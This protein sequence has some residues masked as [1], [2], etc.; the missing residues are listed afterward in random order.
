MTQTRTPC[1]FV[2]ALAAILSVVR[3]DALLA[4][5]N[6]KSAPKRIPWTTSRVQGTPEPPPPFR[7][8]RVF[9]K[10]NFRRP[11]VITSAPGTDRFFVAQNYDK[12]FSIANDPDV[13]KSDLFLDTKDLIEQLNDG[14][15]EE[16][17]MGSIYGLTFHPDFETNRFCYLC[18]VVSYKAGGKGQHPNGTRVV[19]LTVSRTDP[20]VADP[21]SEVL[22]IDWLQG[23]H[24][25]G[26]IK[27]GLDGSLFVSTGD[28]GFAFPP[29][30][31]NSGQDV[32]NLLSA[33]LRIDVD[34]P[35]NGMNYSIPS[36]NP[37]VNLD[38][39]RG[40]IWAYGMRN[41]WKISVDRESGDLW[42]GDVGWESWELVYR[43]Q[44]G[45]NYGW[46]LVEGP[47]P[48]HTERKRGPT[49]IVPPAVA[50]PHTDGAS[51]TG[52]FVYRGKKFPELVG[53]YIFG[54][55]ETRRIW[56]VT[57]DGDKISPMKELVEPTVRIV[58]F[59]ED[60]DGELYLLDYDDG[61]IHTLIRN[62]TEKPKYPFPTKLSESGLFASVADHELADG[63][64][65]YAINA[66]LWADFAT[67]ER[68][69][70]IPGDASVGFHS[71]AVRV[72]GSMFERQTDYPTGTVLG[73]TLS[74][75][76]VKSGDQSQTRRVET[77][78]LHFDGQFWRGYSYEWN[79]E[80]TDAVLLEASGK[81][82]SIPVTKGALGGERNH[83]WKFHS[84]YECLRC[85]NPWSEYTLAFN[86]SQLN[87]VPGPET[88]SSLK[89]NQVDHFRSIGVIRD[90]LREPDPENPFDKG[91]Q[92]KSV[93]ELPRLASPFY[94]DDSLDA[95][96]RAYLHVNCAHCH[97]NGGGGSAYLHLN[98]DLKL[99]ET[100]ALAKRPTQGTFA[101]HDAEIL[102]P[103]DPYRSVLY[104]RLAKLGSGRMPHIGSKL[105]DTEGLDL[106]HDWIR[107]LPVRSEDSGIVDK[108][109]A[110]DE[111]AI[112]KR[113]E[114]DRDRS[115]FN[116]AR[117]VAKE[118]ERE[119]E[120]PTDAD[121][122]EAV[123]RYEGAAAARV[124]KRA[125]DRAS[126]IEELL[127]DPSR[128]ILL[129][130]EH[131][132]NRIPESMVDQVLMTAAK[133]PQP[134]IRD[135]FEIFLP[136]DQRSKRL[137][138]VINPRELLALDGNADRGRKLF[139]ET[140]GIQC[141]NCHR[142]AGKGKSLGPDLD[143][144]AK[145]NSKAKLLDSILD[146]SRNIDPKFAAWLVETTAGRVHVGLLAKKTDEEVV[147]R[148]TEGKE[149]RIAA[150][151]VEEMFPQRKS[152]MPDLQLRDM[153][154]EQVA[155]LLAFLASLK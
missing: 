139:V 112:V 78:L 45:D 54:D 129:L 90:I 9:P 32:S 40:E 21:K 117:A 2:C 22:I 38:D 53:T 118:N 55:W 99:T 128:A 39:A 33:V 135:L 26:C 75:G 96:A 95:R 83:E 134:Q 124:T 23:G 69:I 137:G 142:V 146:P 35:S 125:A 147:L 94:G 64:A 111:P 119:E 140:Q 87:H 141:R 18:Y 85:H 24:N 154:A 148:T 12:V 77:Q 6:A 15:D 28:G 5:E 91:E 70:A 63:V 79:D 66:E 126:L 149:I 82:R 123:K 89:R 49:P 106:I 138:D 31:R 51:V 151:D 127:S 81:Q 130:R 16:V 108:L 143:H 46:S 110:L 72:A 144:I 48:V 153:T 92:V 62:K 105:V 14:A 8:K 37:F 113:E 102:A 52:G 68:F 84:R 97:R 41:P 61:S 71:K 56:G 25:G 36:D 155:D 4:D 58:G 47:Q 67:A 11:T 27:F 65:P 121:Q 20:P 109:I 136:D 86:L 7:A 93:S 98:H 88:G 152:L 42:A 44:P 114:A 100:R 101:I 1:Q 73:K 132:E 116:L 57:R 34:H 80:Q 17:Q 10:I 50:I 115:V 30:G 43:I 29:D 122:A 133:H 131:R 145:K 150:D 104:F 60:H 76:G 3:L 120:Q 19:R 107:Q 103:G 13:S 59:A 74:I